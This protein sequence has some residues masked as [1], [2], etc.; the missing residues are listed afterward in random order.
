MKTIKS[1]AISL[2][3]FLPSLFSQPDTPQLKIS[4]LTGDLYVYTTW[5]DLGGYMYPSNSMYLVTREGVALFDTPWDSTQFQPLLDSI[6]ARHNKKVILCIATHYHDDRT[7]GLEFYKSKGVKTYTSKM[8]WDLC[9]EFDQKQAEFYF[10][11]DTTFNLGGYR[12]KTYYPGEGHTKD[13]I[14]IWFKKDKALYG[15]CLVK[16]TENTGLGNVADANLGEW[17]NSIK[18]VIRKFP[19]PKYVVPGHL[20]WESN[21]GLIHTLELLR[22]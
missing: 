14:V 11:K 8:T 17:G 15:G 2:F 3:L 22:R 18:N 12:I 13:N 4:H 7:A 20:G 10:E 9:E 6:E 19:K 5:M 16:S 21:K 1:T